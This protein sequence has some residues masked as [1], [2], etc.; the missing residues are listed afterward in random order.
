MSKFFLI[1]FLTF[2]LFIYKPLLAQDENVPVSAYP[3]PK[4]IYVHGKG[5]EGVIFGCPNDLSRDFHTCW[6]P[7]V[8]EVG[9]MEKSLK[10]ALL[11]GRI[12]YFKGL[13]LQENQSRRDSFAT[14]F[15]KYKRQYF[16]IL[17]NGRKVICVNLFCGEAPHWK[18]KKVEAN[19]GG[20]CYIQIKYDLQTEKYFDYIENG[21]A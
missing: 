19:D 20:N 12:K 15:F 5:F 7:T 10:T 18:E 3:L 8:E 2:G 21:G 13:N 9:K 1:F 6:I 17:K 14:P 4:T 11:A 16:G